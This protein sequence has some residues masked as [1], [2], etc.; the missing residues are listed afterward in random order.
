MPSPLGRTHRPDH[1]HM[2]Q[3]D[4][5]QVGTL[6]KKYTLLNAHCQKLCQNSF[7]KTETSVLEILLYSINASH[8]SVLYPREMQE[9]YNAVSKMVQLEVSNMTGEERSLMKQFWAKSLSLSSQRPKSSDHFHFLIFQ[10]VWHRAITLST[11]SNW[12]MTKRKVYVS[13]GRGCF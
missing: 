9:K 4:P 8:C 10:D 11:T 1:P 3:R 6:C 12:L 13:I 7:D 5:V 2:P